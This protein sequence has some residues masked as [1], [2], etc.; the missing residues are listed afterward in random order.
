M[1]ESKHLQNLSYRLGTVNDVDA[2]FELNQQSFSEAWSKKSLLDVMLAGF[3]LY[4][5]E[6]ESLLIAYLLSQ[7]ILDEVH[8]MQI[9]VHPQFQ[10]QGI[11][12]QL[13]K[14][15]LHDKSEHILVLLE[16]R[17]SNLAAQT[18]YQNLGFQ[19]IGRRKGY[20]TPENQGEARE[21]AMVM[22]LKYQTAKY[23]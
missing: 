11:G 23:A 13:T 3:D 20:Y 9:S 4:V 19:H 5:C 16:V 6:H 8:I 14:K 17:A 2:V 7:D 22:Q 18:M 12:R 1:K 10:R 21:D 15:L